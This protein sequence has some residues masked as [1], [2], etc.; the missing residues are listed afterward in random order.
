M[1]RGHV[2]VVGE[3]GERAD[4][5]PAC[6][7]CCSKSGP[8]AKPRAGSDER[9]GGDGADGWTV[10]RHEAAARDGLAL[11]RARDAAVGGVLRLLLGRCL[12]HEA[13]N[14]IGCVAQASPAPGVRRVRAASR[15]RGR[16][17]RPSRRGRGRGPHGVGELRSALGVRLR[18]QRDQRRRARRPR[19][20]RRSRPAR[21]RPSA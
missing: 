20:G 18:A 11:E 6:G 4:V 1:T 8:S 15:R 2:G 3:V 13:A 12:S 19:R 17:T 14:A 10:P 7:S 16:V 21:A 5:L 9:G